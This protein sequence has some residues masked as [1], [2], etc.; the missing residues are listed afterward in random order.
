[1][2]A[3]AHVCCCS[4][5]D[6]VKEANK[7]FADTGS[8]VKNS[9]SKRLF[10]AIE[11][12]APWPE[13]LPKGRLLGVKERHMT[14]AFLGNVP[15]PKLEA[16]LQT[17]PK[18][19]FAVGFTGQFDSCL[20]LPP[21]HSNVV[22]WHVR[23]W[24]EIAP[25]LDFQQQLCSWLSAG[26]FLPSPHEPQRPWLPHVTLCRAP[27]DQGAWSKA[28]QPLPFFTVK[29]H[30]YESLGNLRY[31]P[32]WSYD[33]LPPFEELDHTAD[34]AYR[35]YGPTVQDIYLHARTAL[36]FTFPSLQDYFAP[37][38]GFDSLDNIVMALNGAIQ[39]ADSAIG[40]PLKAV[41]FHGAIEPFK[42]NVLA[43]EMIVDV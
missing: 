37:V 36:A 23:W 32:I 16:A 35:I 24:S 22:A 29:I 4:H 27:F 34:I 17:F 2:A 5:K 21:R 26:Q 3:A 19:A 9:D 15:W 14:L 6:K 1:M 20:F 30:L 33:I 10:F 41:S 13:E 42:P 28:F 43:W 12:Q 8:S 38:S 7:N 25:L 31:E 39:R 18:P 40:A 11:V